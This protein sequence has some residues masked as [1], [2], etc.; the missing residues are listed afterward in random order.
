[1]IE[2]V[3]GVENLDAICSIPGVAAVFVGPNDMTVNMGI[4]NEYDH[5][6]FIAVLQKIIDVANR[7]HVAAGCW[8]GKPEQMTRTVRQGARFNVFSNDSTL[9]GEAIS[10]GFGEVR[11]G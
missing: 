7:R 8:F 5:P 4:P 1:M 3:A 11:K 2:S 9:L 6:D 10:R